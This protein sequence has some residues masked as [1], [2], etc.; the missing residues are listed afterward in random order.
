M[1]RR[2]VVGHWAGMVFFN[3]KYRENWKDDR[4]FNISP[5]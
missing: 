2:T 1:T 3:G 4:F 5:L